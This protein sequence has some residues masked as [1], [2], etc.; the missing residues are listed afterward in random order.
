MQAGNG[1]PLQPLLRME[2]ESLPNSRGETQ[3]E[4]HN[5]KRESSEC[6]KLTLLPSLG[7]KL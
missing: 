3:A 1:Q 4:R 6:W 2:P 5:M 7:V